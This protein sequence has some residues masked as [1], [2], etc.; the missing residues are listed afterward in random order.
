MKKGSKS[1]ETKTSDKKPKDAATRELTGD[2]L[3]KVS[4]GINPQP[5]P[6][7]HSRGIRAR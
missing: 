1:R 5:L 3:G 2:S 6:P 4:G 7:E